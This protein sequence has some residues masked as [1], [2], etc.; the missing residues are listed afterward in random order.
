V[1]HRERLEADHRRLDELF[2]A[3]LAAAAGGA[4]SESEAAIA[5]FDEALRAHTDSEEE[6]LYPEPRGG[7]LAPASGETDAKRLARELRLEHVQI[8]ELS[9]MMRRLLSEKGDLP[10]ARA[11]AANL[12]RRWD[13][14]TA[15]EER[16]VFPG[17]TG[18]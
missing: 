9:G 8:R 15:R 18:D 2:G 11:L 6:T 1:S 10:G 4:V 14:H 12:A 13:A 3:F 5:R 16:E 17:L 7:R